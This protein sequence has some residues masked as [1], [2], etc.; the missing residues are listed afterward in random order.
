MEASLA[1]LQQLSRS[2]TAVGTLGI[3]EPVSVD[4]GEVLRSAVEEAGG[5]VQLE[6]P[7]SL[8]PFRGSP[9]DL[10][11]AIGALLA[12]AREAAPP[13]APVRVVAG[14]E[15]NLIVIAVEDPGPGVAVSV[16]QKN[17]DPLF[18]TKGEKGRG[19][20]VTIARLVAALHGGT[21]SIEDRSA[22]GTRV[23]LRLPSA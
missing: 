7:I 9:R 19:V 10:R 13:D 23:S 16:R 4:L 20:G 1:S 15:G 18:S 17:F 22:D 21:L 3:E 11:V 14:V 2:L 8:P 12:N 5:K 6:K